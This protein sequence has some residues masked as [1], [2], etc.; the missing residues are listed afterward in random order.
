MVWR[1]P[2]PRRRRQPRRLSTRIDPPSRLGQLLR[3]R[4]AG[5]LGPVLALSPKAPASPSRRTSLVGSCR[6]CPAGRLGR[7]GFAKARRWRILY[8]SN[9][10]LQSTATRIVT[11]TGIGGSMGKSRG[12]IRQATTPLC[13]HIVGQG[14]GGFVICHIAAGAPCCHTEDNHQDGYV[15]FRSHF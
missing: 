6:P 15:F 3:T 9:R 14:A 12:I 8:W 1:L 5:R 2:P 13:A 10:N 11:W 7:F 4:V